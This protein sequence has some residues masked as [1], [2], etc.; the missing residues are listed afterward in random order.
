[1]FTKEELFA[2]NTPAETKTYTPISHQSLYEVLAEN[3]DKA[4]LQV[5]RELF[6]S[7]RSGQQM[8]GQMVVGSGFDDIDMSLG[9][10]NS[11]DKS[12]QI[13]MV[14][15]GNVI[16]C[17]NGMFK[18]DIR[19]MHMHYGNVKQEIESMA[20]EVVGTLDK[21]FKSLRKDSKKLQEVK[22]DETVIAH[23]LGELFYQQDFLTTTQLKVIKDELELLKNFG[24]ET[25][26]DLYNHTTEALKKSPVVSYVQDHI[27]AHDFYMAKL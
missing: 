10:R 27:Q 4:G 15:G 6:T 25:M 7:A 9:F 2:V 1:M 20:A 23:V 21:H 14:G 24:K 18:G 12:M 3:L 11:Y 5:K 19:K 17:S 8:F 26:W 16:V 13:G 22:I